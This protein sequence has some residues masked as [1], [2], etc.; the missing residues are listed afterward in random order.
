M[1]ATLS[2]VFKINETDGGIN[3]AEGTEGNSEGEYKRFEGDRNDK[4]VRLPSVSPCYS[5]YQTS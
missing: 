5:I 4:I 3:N 2:C 1:L